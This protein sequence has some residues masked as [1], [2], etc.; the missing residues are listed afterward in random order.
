MPKPT[1]TSDADESNLFPEDAPPSTGV[2]T[3]QEYVRRGASGYTK[4]RN[5]FVQSPRTSERGQS[6]PGTL[7]KFARN[8]RAAVLYLA[9]LTNWSWLSRSDEAL[10]ADT[11][12][13]F[14]TC[15]A[16]GALTWNAQSLSH[17][18]GVLEQNQLVTRTHQ[19]RLKKV[20]P[21]HESGSGDAYKRPEGSAGDNYFI[22]PSAFWTE[23]LHG[24]LSWPA[25][26]VLLIL[27][28][29]TGQEPYAELPV[30]RADRYYGVS[31]TAAEKGLAELRMLGLVESRERWVSD[32]DSG[33]GRRRTSLHV[34]HGEFSLRARK[35]LQQA[36]QAR[37]QGKQ[38]D[39]ASKEVMD[40][41]NAES[42][43]G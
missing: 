11:W 39:P 28:K 17:A 29:E 6:H 8:H 7:P 40:D 4:V 36:A 34:L 31:R 5:A 30:D 24:T 10:P 26:A 38:P 1:F 27:L 41:D 16:S 20:T 13:R 9:L 37:R 35:A 23:E 2:E 33:E 14:L 15:E 25:L 3:R 42:E 43:E 32:P 19:K 21:L 12:I 22:L 18:W